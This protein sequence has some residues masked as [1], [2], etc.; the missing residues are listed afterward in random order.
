MHTVLKSQITRCTTDEGA[1]DLDKLYDLVSRAYTQFDVERARSERA[2]R[3]M[4]AEIEAADAQREIVLEKLRQEH[5]KLDIALEH[6]AHGL[7]MFDPRGRLIVANSAYQRGVGHVDDGSEK[8]FSADLLALRHRIVRTDQPLDDIPALMVGGVAV[9]RTVEMSDGRIILINFQPL[10]EG[11][12]VQVL[13]DVTRQQRSDEQIRYL[14]EHDSLTGLSN[15]VVFNAVIEAELTPLP[16]DRVPAV[17]CIDLDHFKSVND[18]LGHPVGDRLLREVADRLRAVAGVGCTIARLGGD[19]FAILLT[20]ADQPAVAEILARA[21]IQA[22]EKPF[23]IDEHHIVIGASVGIAVAPYDGLNAESL[24]RN[25]DIALYR[26]KSD[27][28]GLAQR[29]QPGMDEAILARRQL[30][31]DLRRAIAVGEFELF[32]QPLMNL[33]SQ[34]IESCEALIRWNHPVRGLVPPND[35]IPFAEEIG[36]IVEIG[37]WTMVEACKEAMNWPSHLSVAINVSPNQFMAKGL[38][39]AVKYALQKSGLDATRL[40]LE[41]TESVLISDTDSALAT[42]HELHALGVRIAM[43]D[44]GTGYSSLSYLRRFP[45]DKLKIDRSFI[46]DIAHDREAGAIVRAIIQLA[47]TLG[48][49]TTAEGVEDIDQKDILDALNCR[50][51]QGFLIGRPMPRERL[52]TLLAAP[53]KP[54][55]VA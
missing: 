4:I 31:L 49:A 26:A 43:D 5:L 14:A 46:N 27:G 19:E 20:S 47:N 35:F 3:L 22:I 37:E 34:S 10:K 45:F 39:A 15:R 17:L 48:M 38:I 1:V 11:G 41:V 32:Y 33:K 51:A 12:W 55:A 44:F 23:L 24:M 13:R 25:A 7:A 52:K 8:S 50:E 6:M 42:L 36:L 30:E 16:L 21:I 53:V 29:F 28:R 9:E 18:T 2:T 40:E 54:A